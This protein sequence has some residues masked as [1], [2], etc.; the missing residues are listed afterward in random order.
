MPLAAA[1]ERAPSWGGAGHT[2]S[3]AAHAVPPGLGRA[4][5]TDVAQGG[6]PEVA[7]DPAPFLR[8]R[9]CSQRWLDEALRSLLSAADP[10]LLDG[11][12]LCHLDV[13]SDNL[14]FR[15]DGQ[16]LLIDW[17]CAAAGNPEFDFAFWL[18]SL[19]LEGGPAPETDANVT[20]GFVALVAGF[21]A[22]RAGLPNIP[23]APAV[24]SIQQRQLAVAL[25]WAASVLQLSSP[26]GPS[27]DRRS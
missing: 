21:F 13:R 2:G 9:L 14:C 27:S 26:D 1:V 6:W 12:A 7:R 23:I 18:P 15:P 5:D 22:S 4:V 25:P 3:H 8:L 17:D 20:P 16:A 19:H 24:R 10:A 11:D